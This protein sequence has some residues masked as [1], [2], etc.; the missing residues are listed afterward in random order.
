MNKLLGERKEIRPRVTLLS[1]LHKK[2]VR[3]SFPDFGD[4][5]EEGVDFDP[6]IAPPKT[7]SACSFSLNKVYKD[8][9]QHCWRID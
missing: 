5:E 9:V 8:R 4:E 2:A 7:V 1:K 6:I 3:E